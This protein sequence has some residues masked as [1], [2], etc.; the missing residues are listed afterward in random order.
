MLEEIKILHEAEK[1][2][3]HSF[4]GFRNEKEDHL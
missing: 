1:K 3:H 2:P 4:A